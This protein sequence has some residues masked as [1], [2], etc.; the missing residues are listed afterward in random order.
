MEFMLALVMPGGWVGMFVGRTITRIRR[1]RIVQGKWIKAICRE[2]RV[3][4]KTL[5]TE[6][7]SEATH[8][9]YERELLPMPRLG[10]SRE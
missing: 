7:R 9:Q 8:F 1:A 3:L 5:H 10:A 4:R 2:L 6:P